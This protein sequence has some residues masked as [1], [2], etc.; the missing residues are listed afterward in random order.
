M[1]SFFFQDEWKATPKL[2]VNYGLRYDYATWPY[3]ARNRMTNFDP[4]TGQAFTPANSS[5]GDSLVE[6]DKNNFAPRL[7]LAYRIRPDW[8]LRGGYGRF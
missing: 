7:G 3:E 4:A 2:S 1:T 6:P 5:V 8:V